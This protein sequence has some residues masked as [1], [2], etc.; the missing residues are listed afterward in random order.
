MK[1]RLE[2]IK[3]REE[4]ATPGPWTP[5]DNGPWGS[6]GAGLAIGEDPKY[7]P[8][9]DERTDDIGIANSFFCAHAREDIPWLVDK[10]ERAMKAIEKA[11]ELISEFV[12]ESCDAYLSEWEKAKDMGD[13]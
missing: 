9:F 7:W 1:K 12:P 13:K 11:D 5:F 8:K 4:K 6:Q 3:K 10:L 2:E